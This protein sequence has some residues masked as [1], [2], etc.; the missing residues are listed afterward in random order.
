MQPSDLIISKVRCEIPF[1]LSLVLK[2][3]VNSLDDFDDGR[4]VSQVQTVRSLVS[5]VAERERDYI[6]YFLT[7]ML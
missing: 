5:N 3:K 4:V 1:Y 2:A 7:N 6:L